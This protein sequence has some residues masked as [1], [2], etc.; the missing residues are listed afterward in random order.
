[1]NLCSVA[2]G[3][4]AYALGNM[5]LIPVNALVMNDFDGP[6]VLLSGVI[7]AAAFA[8]LREVV[9]MINEFGL[10]PDPL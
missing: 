7:V 9:E 4:L 6:Q 8:A 2:Y 5:I 1:M 3:I 10:T